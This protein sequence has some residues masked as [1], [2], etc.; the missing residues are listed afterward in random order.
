MTMSSRSN[1]K[2]YDVLTEWLKDQPDHLLPK[3][4]KGLDVPE[5]EG[6]PYVKTGR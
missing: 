3:L 4:H 5:I 2:K 6:L 1:A